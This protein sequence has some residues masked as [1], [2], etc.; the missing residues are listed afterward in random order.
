MTKNEFCKKWR[1]GWKDLYFDGSEAY[2]FTEEQMLKDLDKV[3]HSTIFGW[4]KFV[5]RQVEISLDLD[6]WQRQEAEAIENR[7]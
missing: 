2:F 3:I 1:H 4:K 6:E 5:D 7:K